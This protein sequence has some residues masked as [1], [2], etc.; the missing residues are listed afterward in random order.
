MSEFTIH[1]KGWPPF[2]KSMSVYPKDGLFICIKTK[3]SVIIFKE[4]RLKMTW[5]VFKSLL[6]LPIWT[7]WNNIEKITEKVNQRERQ[8]Y[9]TFCSF[10]LTFMN[11]SNN[12][13]L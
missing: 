3:I 11:L 9:S 13:L 2:K 5:R 7:Y 1:L 4:V 10:I 6:A 8:K 12:G